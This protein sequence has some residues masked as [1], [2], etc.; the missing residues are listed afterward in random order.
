MVRKHLLLVTI[1]L[2]S[3]K[4]FAACSAGLSEVIVKIIPDNYPAEVSWTVTDGLG[5]IVAHGDSSASDTI[6][7]PAASCH[8]FTIYDTFGDGIISPGGYWLYVDGVLIGNGSAFGATAQ[9]TFNCPPGSYCSNPI[10]LANGSHT[11]Q[12][13]DTWY[14]YTPAVSGTYLLNTCGLNTCDTKIWVY[15]SCPPYPYSESVQGTFAFNDDY[16]CGVQAVLNVILFAGSHYLIRI[17]DNLDSCSGSVVFD[18]SYVGPVRGCM[19]INACNYNPLASQDDSSCVY[20]PSPLCNGPDLRLDS[21]IFVQSLSLQSHYAATCDVDEGCVTGYGIRNVISFTSHIDNV[22]TQ[23]FFIGNST[24]QPGMFNTNNCH[25]HAHYEGYGDYRLFDSNNNLV[26]AGHK[27]GYCILDL[28]GHG[29]YTCG[30]MGISAGCYDAYDSGTQCQ[31]IDITDVPSG[32]YRIAVIINSKHLPD[33]LGR[34]ETNYINNAVQICMHI[35]HNPGGVPVYTLLPNCAPYIDCLGVPGGNSELDCNGICNGP[36]IFGDMF[37]DGVL[38]SQDVS[39]YL[40]ILQSVLPAANC[41][42]LNSDNKLSIYDAALVNWCR[43]GNPLHPGGSTHNHCNFPRN[44]LNPND[45]VGLSISNVD[46]NNNYVDVEILNPLANVKAYQF[47]M[48]GITISSVVSLASPIDFPVEV[49]FIADSNEVFAISLED[50]SLQRSNIGQALVR[51]Y[52]SA[53]TDTE[54]C[55]FSITDIVNQDAERTMTNIFGN[56]YA[57]EITSIP[58][59]M[60][61]ADLVLLPNPAKDRAFIHLS[62]EAGSI[63]ELIVMDVSGKIYSVPRQIIKGS[64]YELNLQDLPSGVYIVRLRN[65]K[66]YGATRFIKL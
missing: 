50:S 29:Q 1:I 17:G 4:I 44:I 43:H 18:F 60:K 31:W 19:D 13:D 5:N 39:A 59:L 61:Q 54:I 25:G 45:L 27:N 42:D 3:T 24:T 38:D 55:I 16:N 9:Y 7:I 48:S 20:F 63:S 36:G 65:N 30:N 47:K 51:I 11:A 52:F 49:R 12:F 37:Q 58:A 15:G 41:N 6:C 40:N 21:T 56:C 23:D 2:F 35:V 8:F 64:W 57:S 53:I 33:A 62:D 22:G 32:D 28:C 34:Y 10:P 26:P 66:S 46:F 14:D